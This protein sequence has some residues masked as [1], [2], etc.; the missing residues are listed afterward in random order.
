MDDATRSLLACGKDGKWQAVSTWKEPVQ[1]YSDL[2]T[3]GNTS[4]DVRMVKAL[5]RAFTYDGSGW[6]ALAVDQNGN[7]SVPD[8][9]TVYG[10]RNN[11]LSSYW[12]EGQS[13]YVNQPVTA[14]TPC[15]IPNGTGVYLAIGT[16]R[17][18]QNGYLLVCA[19]DSIFRYDD[20][21]LT[22]P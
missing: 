20:G 3:T 22:H 18:D 21:S 8:T 6:V 10:I 12:V 9:L 11:W 16:I 17:R 2:P 15:N 7:M 13:L 19:W 1:N 14:G 5:S 4:G